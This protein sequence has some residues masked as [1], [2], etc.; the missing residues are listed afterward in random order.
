[1]LSRSK[2]TCLAFECSRSN[3]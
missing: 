2:V 3:G 1:V